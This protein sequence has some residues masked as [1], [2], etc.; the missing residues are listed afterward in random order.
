MHYL[1]LCSLSFVQRHTLPR[2]AQTGRLQHGRPMGRRISPH[3]A[4]HCRARSEAVTTSDLVKALVYL[5]KAY[6]DAFVYDGQYSEHRL[7][8]LYG[9][10]ATHLAGNKF[11]VFSQN[12]D[13]SAD[14]SAAERTCAPTPTSWPGISTICC[15]QLPNL[16]G[17]AVEAAKKTFLSR[18]S[19]AR[20]R[21][22][23]SSP[24]SATTGSTARSA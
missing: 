2:P 21:W 24:R 7:K 3:P 8:M 22:T 17:E 15:S 4:R 10:S 13:S 16:T 19:A 6:R 23:R 14:A 12:R 1:P 5:A 11:I 18:R 20:R 9:I